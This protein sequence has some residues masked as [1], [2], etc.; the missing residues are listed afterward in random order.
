MCPSASARFTIRSTASNAASFSGIT[1]LL[2][3]FLLARMWT[4][5]FSAIKVFSPHVL[6]LNTAH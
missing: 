4:T 2:V 6:H 1:R 3:S 5:R